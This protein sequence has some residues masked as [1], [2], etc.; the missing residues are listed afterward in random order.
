MFR[1][2]YKCGIV[3]N[4]VI[5]DDNLIDARGGLKIGQNCNFSTGVRIWT[6]QHDYQS[7]S[8]A[9]ESAPVK[10]GDYCW[11][12]G[13]VTILPGVNIGEGTVIASGA[14]ITKD[15]EHYSVY[16]GVP[17]R[18]IGTRT[19]NLAYSFNGKHDMFL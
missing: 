9:Y 17:G 11:L 18:K 4:T 1:D 7:E 13:N 15:C 3:R 10:I 19:K 5:G 14:V 6:A 2:G 16:G 12:S 8:F